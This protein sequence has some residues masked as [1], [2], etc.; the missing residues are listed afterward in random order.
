MLF[1]VSLL[2]SSRGLRSWMTMRSCVSA[3]RL[4]VQRTVT[5][6][7]PAAAAVR[8]TVPLSLT[9]ATA[10]SEVSKVRFVTSLQLSR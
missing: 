10:G 7:T 1:R 8:V 5:V 4:S 3:R 9:L 6:Q 2:V